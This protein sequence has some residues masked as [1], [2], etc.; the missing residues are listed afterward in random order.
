MADASKE[1]PGF[2]R[3]GSVPRISRP[4]NA[5]DYPHLNDGLF[6]LWTGNDAKWPDGARVTK[7]LTGKRRDAM[8]G[9]ALFTIDYR[10]AETFKDFG[11]AMAWLAHE[12]TLRPNPYGVRVTTIAELKIARGYA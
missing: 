12:E 5:M 2:V 3:V 9:Y 7:Y 8:K 4:E 11:E 1:K 10:D 6:V